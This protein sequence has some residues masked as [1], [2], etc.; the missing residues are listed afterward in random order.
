MASESVPG[1]PAVGKLEEI[2]LPDASDAAGAGSGAGSGVGAGASVGAGSGAGAGIGSGMGAGAGA[3]SVRGAI[4][5]THE[6]A[7]GEQAPAHGPVWNDEHQLWGRWVW[8]DG[9]KVFVA[10]EDIEVRH[11][12]RGMDVAAPLSRT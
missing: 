6:G 3:G 12:D 2:A 10:D 4:P 9:E 8:E 1:S 5:V 7:S 11:G